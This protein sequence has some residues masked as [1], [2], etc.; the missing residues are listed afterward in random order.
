[1]LALGTSTSRYIHPR[2]PTSQPTTAEI[3]GTAG[4]AATAGGSP[5][6]TPTRLRGVRQVYYQ[7]LAACR[8]KHRWYAGGVRHGRSA[9]GLLGWVYEQ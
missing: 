1:M 9:A 3:R 4:K 5:L 2:L 6:R 8:H 7:A